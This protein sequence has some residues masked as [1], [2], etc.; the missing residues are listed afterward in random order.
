[1]R[2]RFGGISGGCIYQGLIKSS[3]LDR[4]RAVASAEWPYLGVVDLG[5]HDHLVQLLLVRLHLR[6]LPHLRNRHVV[7]VP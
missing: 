6:V 2:H 4:K 5:L 7:L 3:I 1:M